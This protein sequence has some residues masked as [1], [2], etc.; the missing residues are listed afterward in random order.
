MPGRIAALAAWGM[1]AG[2]D[3]NPFD[4]LD[5]RTPQLPISEGRIGLQQPERVRVGD[6]RERRLDA[7][8]GDLIERV[9]PLEECVDG[10]VEHPCDLRETTGAD[11]VRSLLV[12]LHLLVCH[13]EITTE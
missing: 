1:T 7:L 3:R 2:F 6:E 8:R 9:A 4:Q 13:A 10:Y 12:F 5:D 11:A